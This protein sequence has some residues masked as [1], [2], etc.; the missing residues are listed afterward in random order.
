[1]PHKSRFVRIW[2]VAVAWFVMLRTATLIVAPVAK[3]TKLL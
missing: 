1:V 2:S 3:L